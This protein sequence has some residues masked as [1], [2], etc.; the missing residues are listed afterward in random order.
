MVSG[1]IYA[2]PV[3]ILGEDL[4]IEVC[5]GIWAVLSVRVKTI[6]HTPTKIQILVIQLTGNSINN[7]YITLHYIT[8]HSLNP[9]LVNMIVGGGMCHKNTKTYVQYN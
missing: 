9:K 5:V 1:P 3:L 7:C 8:L 4:R 2:L 6:I